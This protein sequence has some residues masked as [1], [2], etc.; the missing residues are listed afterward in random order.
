MFIQANWLLDKS[1]V[2]A[3]HSTRKGGYSALPYQSLNLGYHVNDSKQDVDKN[4]QK[5][6]KILDLVFPLQMV[7]QV[8]GNTVLEL[9][10]PLYRALD[11][12]SKTFS[13]QDLPR[14][15]ALYTRVRQLPLCILTADCLPIFLVNKVC[16]EIAVIHGGWRSLS[17][18]IIR[19]TLALFHAKPWDIIAYMGAAIGAQKFEVGMEVKQAFMA[20]DA[21][22]ATAFV[23]TG[24]SDKSLADLYKIGKLLLQASGV[25]RCYQ[26]DFCTHTDEDLFFSY[27]RDGATGRMGN[28]I[29][30]L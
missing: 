9:K 14:A 30:L 22:L 25:E 10:R 19:N 13:Y 3:V 23:Q 7:Q 5:V 15:D 1:R 29:W 18:G 16:D 21:R 11:E 8:H 26:R 12:M 28:V 2:A 4:Q 24:H 6:Q 17:Q 27:R 20:V